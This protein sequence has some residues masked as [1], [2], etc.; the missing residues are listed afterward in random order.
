MPSIAPTSR[1][2]AAALAALAWPA[3]AQEPAEPPGALAPI[4]AIEA[5]PAPELSAWEVGVLEQGETAPP[6]GLWRGSTPAQ[7]A[8]AFE[9]TPSVIAS[10]LA[11]R[12]ALRAL[13]APAEAPAA[14][15]GDEA[16][17]ALLER[18]EALGRLGAA[19]RLSSM[20]RATGEARRQPT[21]ALFAAQADF[22]LGAPE[23][24][25]RRIAD[26]AEATPEILKFRALCFAL[27]G[28]PAATDL[29][30]EV[31][32]SAQAA[33]AFLYAA[34]PLI[35]GG[36]PP[37]RPPA[38]RF[39]TSRNAF[40][41]LRANL[42]PAAKPLA[43]ASNL[44]LIV[45]AREEAAAPAIRAEA[46]ELALSRGLIDARLAQEGLLAVANGWPAG[47][48]R[49]P[50]LAQRAKELAGLEPGPRNGRIAE[51]FAAAKT[52]SERAKLARLFA[53][54]I[55]AGPRGGEPPAAAA[56]LAQAALLLADREAAA[57]W[58]DLLPA[59][60][61]AGLKSRLDAALAALA[62]AE[63]EGAAAGL[64][65][66]AGAQ[67]AAAARAVAILGGLGALS[68]SAQVYGA[69]KAGGG[70]KAAEAAL[71]ALVEASNRSAI[72]ETMLLAAAIAAPGAATLEARAVL[73]VIEALRKVGLEEE[74][75]WLAVEAIL[76]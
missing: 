45:V 68:P 1:I 25:C 28:Q 63:L 2:V 44:A 46:I 37:A 60:A 15:E 66:A 27:E 57:R 19:F 53:P 54:E 39:N 13:A 5:A 7:L 8:A 18:Y 23:E 30:I 10:P 58:R 70:A 49:P 62:G 20:V 38:A 55:Q 59:D 71:G 43:D 31:A 67:E 3:Q 69:E 36:A 17:K 51:L 6:A 64:I 75:R 26:A 14:A 9:Q 74:A 76:G 65:A 4:E 35:S 34:L 42:K 29:A 11:R 16:V 52:P 32:R 50:A 61:G 40:V 33:D 41:S 21:L 56:A 24:G 12:L 48:T 47:R 73:A 72:G 22:A